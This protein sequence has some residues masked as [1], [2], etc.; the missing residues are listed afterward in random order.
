MINNL[1]QAQ[2]SSLNTN[3]KGGKKHKHHNKTTGQ[4]QMR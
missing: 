1:K 4:G 2:K 3:V